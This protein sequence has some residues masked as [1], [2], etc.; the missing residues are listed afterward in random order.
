MEGEG[1]IF[2]EFFSL[3]IHHSHAV[4]ISFP[5]AAIWLDGPPTAD[6]R[7]IP[8]IPLNHA[9]TPINVSN[10]EAHTKRSIVNKFTDFHL[11]LSMDWVGVEQTSRPH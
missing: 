5:M 3:F 8:A 11:C 4:T 9:A 1:K 2:V 6:A 7:F 10:D